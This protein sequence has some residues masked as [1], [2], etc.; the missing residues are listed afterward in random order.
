MCVCVGGWGRYTVTTTMTL[1]LICLGDV[2]VEG[3]KG[4][5]E[6]RDYTNA[7]LSPPQ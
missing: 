6:D 3:G 7:T 5:G 2:C 4:G 1:G